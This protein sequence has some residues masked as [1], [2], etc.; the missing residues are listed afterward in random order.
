MRLQ[1]DNED[2]HLVH[3]RKHNEYW[4]LTFVETPS[5]QDSRRLGC[6]VKVTCFTINA[7]KNSVILVYRA[8]SL[9]KWMNEMVGICI[10]GHFNPCR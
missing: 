5:H 10:A 4:E 2:R 3:W 8:V 9:E 7:F 1:D 6:R